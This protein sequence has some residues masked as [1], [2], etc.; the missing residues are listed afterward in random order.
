MAANAIRTVRRELAAEDE[1]LAEEWAGLDALLGSAER[2]SGRAALREALAD[3]NEE[4]C[5]RIRR[6]EADDGE[7]GERVREHVRRTVRDK[8]RVSDPGLLE[9]SEKTK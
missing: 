3:W 2:P 7:W 4:L 1:Q 8:L 5:E 9:R 6:G